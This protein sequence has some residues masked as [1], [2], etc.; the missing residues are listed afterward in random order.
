MG[1]H[2]IR[3]G[4][5]L[6]ISG[7][8]AATR[9]AGAAVRH[10][11]V[12]GADYH[13]MKP[14][15]IAQVG[16]RVLRG[17]QLFEDRKTEGVFF[18]APGTGTVKAIHRGAKRAFL[19]LVIEL[20]DGDAADEQVA[21][22]SWT[23]SAP[24]DAAGVQALLVESGLWTALRTRP[25]S[26][27]PAPGTQPRSLFVTA[28][29]TSPLAPDVDA[30][31][32]AR[33]ED[34]AAGLKALRALISGNVY[35]CVGKGSS[36]DAAGVSGVS[37]EQFGGKHPAGLPGTHIHLL[38]PAG[39]E[40]VQWS[41]GAQD[42][43]AIGA[44]CQTGKLDVRRV[45]S[46]AGPAASNPRH[47]ETRLGASTDELLAGEVQGGATA[48]VVSG[49][50]LAGRS[51]AGEVSGFLG[52]YHQQLSLLEEGGERKFM[53]WLTPGGSAFSTI[54]IYL[55]SL[56]PGKKFA[57]DTDTNGS[58]RAMVPIGMYERV[59]PLDILPTFLLRSLAV[60]DLEQAE[61]LGALELDEED[62]ALCTFVCP[63]KIDYGSHLRDVLTQIEKEG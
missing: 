59:M 45:V 60:G 1:V 53:G 35:L 55:S 27:V 10:V 3:K 51:A 5:D 41:I 63:G 14:R 29:D 28:I 62:L 34:W 54:R 31:V 11:A 36:I 50:V 20:D 40:R 16:D 47:L 26:K 52:R 56:M 22:E 32:A 9:E 33:K 24:T 43:L 57:F 4:L 46:V 8:P 13:G 17:Q 7:A 6:P 44:L 39:R 19:S 38:D 25:Y 61:K 21:F 37:V 58:H 12:L 23:G 49:S 2:S 15:M 18:T 30:I 42:V 48:R